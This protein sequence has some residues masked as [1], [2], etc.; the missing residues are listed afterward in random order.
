[1]I[2]ITVEDYN[3]FSQEFYD[4]VI[5]SLQLHSLKCKCGH[6]G[7]LSI[8]AYYKRGVA[9]PAGIIILWICRVKCSGCGHTHALLLSSMVPY[10]RVT[11][12]DQVEVAQAVENHTDRNNLTIRNPFISIHQVKLISRRYRLHWRQRLL[13]ER[14][15]F[16]PLARLVK[17]CFDIYSAQF[18]QI[19]RL[20]NVLF[21][22]FT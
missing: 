6:S 5:N 22:A 20:P 7:C 21:S 18:L 10:S 1:M 14:I 17:E 8:H 2:T 3:N 15:P 19:S 13:S 12:C 4:F 9:T 16:L 11:L